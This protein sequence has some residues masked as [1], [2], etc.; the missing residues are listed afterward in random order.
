MSRGQVTWVLLAMA[1]G[2]FMVNIDLTAVNVALASIERG[3]DSDITTIQWVLNAYLLAFSVLLVQGGRLVDIFGAKRMFVGGSLVF[4]AASAACGAAPSDV[5]LIAARVVQGVGGAMMWPALLA[6][7][8]HTVGPD[9]QASAVGFL[10][11]GAGV[12]QVV[13]PI[14]GGVLTEAVSWRWIFLIN[15]PVAV[16]V[17]PVVLRLV[18]Q[19]RGPR[20]RVD[21]LGAGLLLAPLAALFIALD[22]GSTWGWDSAPVIVLV[23]TFFVLLAAFIAV[24][25]R[26]PAPLLDLALFRSGE[27]VG[28]NVVKAT[29]MFAFLSQLLFIPLYMQVVLGSTPLEAGLALMPTSVLLAVCPPITGR[30]VD[31]VGTQ[32]PCVVGMSLLAVSGVVLFLLGPGDSYWAL[33][34]GV[35]LL[36]LGMGACNAAGTT[37]AIAGA[38]PEKAG[39]ASGIVY[40]LGFVGGAL[41]IAITTAIYNAVADNRLVNLLSGQGL[42]ATE[43]QRHALFDALVD[44]ELP[45][46]AAALFPAQAIPEV[47]SF[48]GEAFVHG[49]GV[50]MLVGAGATLLGALATVL[51]IP[52][53]IRPHLGRVLFHA[54]P[55]LHRLAAPFPAHPVE[56]FHH[57]RRAHA[58]TAADATA[59]TGGAAPSVGNTARHPRE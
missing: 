9:R 15:V 32:I 37:A 46:R 54:P 17:V 42:N 57:W 1:T 44:E 2:M 22:Q 31:R 59:G 48:I 36:G 5:F 19:Q 24:E 26:T 34:P 53:P 16:V 21:H 8:V 11:A 56:S 18:K 6:I 25:R 4:A 10:M 58:A 41:G 49:F 52:G 33:F 27:F 12:A 30:I 51:L 45:E 50:A 28:G 3:L 7:A 20:E 39:V 13:G 47:E 14:L 23:V 38:G 43:D 55:A 40:M 35:L 29:T